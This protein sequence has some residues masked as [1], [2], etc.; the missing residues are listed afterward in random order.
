ME[1]PHP[2]TLIFL[3][4]NW[5]IFDWCAAQCEQC[6]EQFRPAMIHREN[7]ET[8]PRFGLAPPGLAGLLAECSLLAGCGEEKQVK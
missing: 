3:C 4:T 5:K 8:F 7:I 6:T 2:K 1:T